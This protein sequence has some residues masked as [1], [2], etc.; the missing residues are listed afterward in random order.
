MAETIRQ[1]IV[2]GF[3]LA[4]K[5]E[6][7]PKVQQIQKDVARDLWDFTIRRTPR[8][9]GRLQAHWNPSIGRMDKRKGVDAG[10]IPG[11]YPPA[12][13]GRLESVLGSLSDP[14]KPKE[15]IINNSVPYVEQVEFV[16]TW[17]SPPPLLMATRAVAEVLQ[18]W[19]R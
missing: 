19:N 18:K 5:N 1:Q 13:R 3:K 11:F 8:W 2:N 14:M 16:G 12:D 7:A 17:G 15:V 6:A 9:T 4:I 10:K